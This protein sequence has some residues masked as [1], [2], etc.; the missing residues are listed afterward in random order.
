M[1]LQ[2]HA[3][4][5]FSPSNA[6]VAALERRLQAIYRNVP[7]KE[8][9]QVQ[10]YDRIF[11][12]HGPLRTTKRW[13]AQERLDAS[14]F[15]QFR[16]KAEVALTAASSWYGG[17]YFEFG[18][19]DLNT[20]RNMLS[21]YSINGL[22]DPYPDVRFYAFDIFGKDATSSA[23]TRA[24]I[25]AFEAETSYFAPFT[26]QGD[27][28]ALHERYLDQHAIYRDKCHLVQGYFQD[29]LTPEFRASYLADGRQI[30]FA[31]LDVNMTPSYQIVFDFIFEMMA[32]ASYLYM[33][34]YNF[35]DVILMF[36]HFTDALRRERNIGCTY[37]RNA[38]GFGALFRLHDLSNGTPQ[39]N[40]T[41]RRNR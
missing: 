35:S 2:R 17:D 28:L 25:D 1:K 12:F 3:S 32:P 21:A 38:G 13:T 31:F 27:T 8:W 23:E 10:F 20:F 41:S 14:L 34:E 22:D 37:V 36:E 16:E 40:L 7:E 19:H 11:K 6:D 33:D 5:R 30:G 15:F 26:T 39:L 4:A 24:S 9:D 29:T 18:A